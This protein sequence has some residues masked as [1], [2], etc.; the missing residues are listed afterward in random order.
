MKY[1]FIDRNILYRK[2]LTRLQIIKV[3]KKKKG[4]WKE[5]LEN[6]EYVLIIFNNISVNI[7]KYKEKSKQ[8][9][10]RNVHWPD[11]VSQTYIR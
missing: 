7:W 11:D 9:Q 2:L 6:I 10:K 4:F 1:L 5:K 3:Y 8:N